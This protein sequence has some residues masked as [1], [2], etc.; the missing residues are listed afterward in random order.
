MTLL[1]VVPSPRRWSSRASVSCD[2]SRVRRASTSGW[3]ATSA[4]AVTAS[5]DALTAIEH[6]PDCDNADRGISL[7]IRLLADLRDIFDGARAL[8]TEDIL[9]QLHALDAAPWADLKGQPLDARGLARLLDPYDITPAKVKVG[10]RALQGYR[11]E[12]L[13]DAWTRYLPPP[14]LGEA[15][16]A[17]PPEPEPP[18]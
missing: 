4:C 6:R 17:E 16:P 11:A 7:G 8:A 10:G 13:A 9:T 14:D 1:R 2:Q 12:H 18:P 3:R 5:V 15:E